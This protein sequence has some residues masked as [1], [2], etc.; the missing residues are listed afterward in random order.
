[1]LRLETGD[2]ALDK[3]L[4]VGI[5]GGD[6]LVSQDIADTFAYWQAGSVC[7]IFETVGDARDVSRGDF[8]PALLFVAAARGGAL[9]VSGQ[10]L[11]WLDERAVITLDLRDRSQ[12]PHWQHLSRPFTQ[13]Q[14]IDAVRRLMEANGPQRAE[15]E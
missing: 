1:M 14:V 9:D 2:C 13:A 7:R 8:D 11:A 12:F 5:I 6:P 4:F 3:T 10:E 15:V